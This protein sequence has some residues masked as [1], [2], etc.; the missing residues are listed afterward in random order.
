MRVSGR[1]K[2]SPKDPELQ[3]EVKHEKKMTAH[4]HMENIRPPI[5]VDES[6]DVIVFA[7]VEHA[8]RYLEPIDVE[9]NRCV[10]YDSE[11]RLLK[12]RPTEP[13]ITI[14]SAEAVPSHSRE[15]R[16]ILIEFLEYLG[17]SREWLTQASLSELVEKASPYATK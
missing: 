11:G 5:I 10:A 3:V 1:I 12:L 7:S 6:G 4:Y 14:E 16:D 13:R 17:H 8:E 2:L 9:E 15:V